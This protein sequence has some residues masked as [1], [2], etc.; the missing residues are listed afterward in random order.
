MGKVAN[1]AWAKQYYTNGPSVASA[2]HGSDALLMYSGALLW[3]VV[4][5]FTLLLITRAV[6]RL[7]VQISSAGKLIGL[8][9]WLEKRLR[10]RVVAMLERTRRVATEKEQQAIFVCPEFYHFPGFANLYTD[11]QKQ[12]AALHSLE[13]SL[14]A[15][16]GVIEGPE[17]E[18]RSA[19]SKL[20]KSTQAKDTIDKAAEVIRSTAETQILESLRPHIYLAGRGR[21]DAEAQ[22]QELQ[23][24]RK[25]T[26]VPAERMGVLSAEREWR[27][28]V[29]RWVAIARLLNEVQQKWA[30]RSAVLSSADQFKEMRKRLISVVV[31]TVA[32]MFG[33]WLAQWLFWVGFVRL[34]TPGAYCPPK[35]TYMALTWIFFS[36]F[37]APLGA[38]I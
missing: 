10:D 25:P 4:A 33:C 28:M 24:Q 36:V 35:L 34:Y 22:S 38:S 12:I 30:T 2:P 17:R 20:G 26:Q 7:S 15:L 3:L 9:V 23:L 37:G 18:Y 21:R 16:I 6:L 1:F 31:I 27:D 5:F 13:K 29:R 19:L 32:G 11:V 8:D 14:E